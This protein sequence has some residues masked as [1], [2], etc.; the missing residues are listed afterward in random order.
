M[1]A[2]ENIIASK[3]FPLTLVLGVFYDFGAKGGFVRELAGMTLEI[4]ARP[5]VHGAREPPSGREIVAAVSGRSHGESGF[6]D[7][8][9]E[10]T[11]GEPPIFDRGLVPPAGRVGSGRGQGGGEIS[12]N[13]CFDDA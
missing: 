5:S 8:R 12:T 4:C 3:R 9:D 11:F 2:S 10:P 13:V 1:R 7:A 6:G